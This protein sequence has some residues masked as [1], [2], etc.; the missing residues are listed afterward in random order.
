MVMTDIGKRETGERGFP[1]LN[2]NFK[3]P[4][5]SNPNTLSMD[6]SFQ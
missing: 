5:D 6:T 1:T 4:L 2:L 3:T